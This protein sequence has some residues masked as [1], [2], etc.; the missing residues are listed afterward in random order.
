MEDIEKAKSMLSDT[1]RCAVIKEGKIFTSD[2][3]GI[4]PLIELYDGGE[5]L[6]GCVAADKIVGKAAAF[7]YVRL[8]AREVYASVM[9]GEAVK[10]LSAFGIKH[11]FGQC[12]KSIRNRAGDGICPMER[13]VENISDPDEA[14]LRLRQTVAALLRG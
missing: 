3:R 14:I 10:V 5:D 1:I 11:S 9:S 8:K 4:A 7:I 2:R 12:V 13:A 6:S